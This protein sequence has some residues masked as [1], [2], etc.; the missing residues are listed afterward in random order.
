MRD[1]Q[2]D[3]ARLRPPEHP[4]SR[5]E[6][7]PRRAPRAT[8]RCSRRV[9]R[10]PKPGI[11]YA[12]TRRGAEELAAA[13]RDARR[14]APAPTTRGCR[15]R[16]ASAAQ[17]ALHGR[18]TS[19]SSSRPIAFGMGIDKPNVRFVFH[20][21]RQRVGRLLLPGDRPRRPRRRAG[22]A[23]CS[24]T[25][26][27]TSGCSGSSPARARRAPRSELVGSPRP[28]SAARGPVELDGAAASDGPL[29]GKLDGRARRGSSDA[30]AVE[31][32]PGRRRS[33]RRRRDRRRRPSRGPPTREERRRELRALARRHDPRLRRAARL[34][35][36]F[37]L[38]YFG[39]PRDGAVR[40]LRQLRAG[41]ASPTAAAA[42]VRAR[43]ARRATRSGARASSSATRATRRRPLRRGR[44]QDARRS[45]SSSSAACSR[46]SRRRGGGRA[47]GRARFP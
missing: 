23:P 44:L 40:L 39:E 36:R 13:L 9:G 16:R 34:P 10:A 19:T 38:D 22:R 27:R 17:D 4:S 3:R 1:P 14:R 45:T 43:G 25:A 32:A 26:P 30:G 35:A 42:A 20:A 41:P 29:P 21:E 31:I 6:Q 7:L 33:S 28:S 47:R 11:V 18:T 15:R 2:V 5:V 24:S 8:R 12:A 46:R 37:L